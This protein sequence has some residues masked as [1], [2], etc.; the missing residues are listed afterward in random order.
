MISFLKQNWNIIYCH[1]YSTNNV[2]LDSQVIHSNI[3]ILF[4]VQDKQQ[5]EKIFEFLKVIISYTFIHL[6]MFIDFFQRV[7]L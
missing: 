4:D 2:N 5:E 6:N 1:L 3:D 7:S